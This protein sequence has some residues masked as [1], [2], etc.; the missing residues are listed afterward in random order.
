MGYLP[1]SHGL[2]ENCV[3]ALREVRMAMSISVKTLI[4]I[5]HGKDESVISQGLNLAV[6]AED[7]VHLCM[8][9]NTHIYTRHTHEVSVSVWD[10]TGAILGPGPRG[11]N[12]AHAR[13]LLLS[14]LLP[15]RVLQL[16]HLEVLLARQRTTPAVKRIVMSSFT[17]ATRPCSVPRHGASDCRRQMLWCKPSNEVKDTPPV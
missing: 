7:S 15:Q 2:V 16:W 11:F 9:G 8:Y 5:V 14:L 12:E 13:W 17:N 10:R 1:L 3:I 6:I 4:C